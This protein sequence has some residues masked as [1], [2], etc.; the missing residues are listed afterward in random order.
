MSNSKMDGFIARYTENQKHARTNE[1][2]R[3]LKRIHPCQ[4]DNNM[5][6]EQ[7]DN[8]NG[9][10]RVYVINKKAFDEVERVRNKCRLYHMSINAT[11]AE[12]DDLLRVGFV[13]LETDKRLPQYDPKM[14]HA[15]VIRVEEAQK[16]LLETNFEHLKIAYLW[17]LLHLSESFVQH[18]APSAAG[19]VFLTD[20]GLLLRFI[21]GHLSPYKIA[22]TKY[23]CGHMTPLDFA[24]ECT[25]QWMEL[26]PWKKMD[27]YAQI[28]PTDLSTGIKHLLA[29]PKQAG[30]LAD[31]PVVKRIKFADTDT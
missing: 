29:Q 19:H 8:G 3:E 16:F 14:Q 7:E 17:A 5:D 10:D 23:Y 25:K 28:K 9:A 26:E 2:P 6:N 1:V 13:C 24:V 22:F 4:L 21:R 12:L 18:F 27:E 30:E 20:P 11:R 15:D 31:K